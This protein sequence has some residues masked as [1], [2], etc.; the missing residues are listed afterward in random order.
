MERNKARDIMTFLGQRHLAQAIE[1]THVEGA[2]E[3]D[4]AEITEAIGLA[5]DALRDAEHMEM[6]LTQ[7]VKIYEAR[8]LPKAVKARLRNTR[9][10]AKLIS[11]TRV[12]LDRMEQSKGRYSQTRESATSNLPVV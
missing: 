3:V 2:D 7:A 5:E 8:I 12:V 1:L 9:R 6:I 11:S 10:F 4:T